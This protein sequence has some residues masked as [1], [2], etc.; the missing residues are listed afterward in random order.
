MP[1]STNPKA[2]KQIKVWDAPTR[3]F[4]WALVLLV[5]LSYLTGEFGGFDFTMPGSG[6]LI[7]NMTVHMWSGLTILT[8]VL[9][10][11]AWG[12]MGSTTAR[13][14]DFVA[15]PGAIIN[16]LS[17]LAKRVV[18]FTA[19]HNPAG[20]AMVVL[21]LILLIVQ[22]GLGLFAKEDD[23]LGIA[24]PLNSLVSEDS[25]KILTTRHKQVWGYIELL[26]LMHIAANL[27]YWLVLKQNLIAA[28]FTGKK[29]APD[30]ATVAELR[31]ASPTVAVVVLAIAA[32]IVWGITRLG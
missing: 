5:L 2:P 27:L 13:F 18:K 26:V 11:V 28:M 31:F 14:S 21:M 25:A 22:A 32:A 16:Y 20:G 17:G 4:H 12:F 10:R 7:A 9:F 19:G 3:L 23:F 30:G 24:G 6:D 29:D 1:G 8:L 15:G